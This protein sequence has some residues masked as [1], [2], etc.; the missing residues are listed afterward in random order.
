MMRQ[1][2]LTRIWNFKNF[3]RKDP[4]LPFNGEGRL[5][6]EGDEEMVREM[7]GRKGQKGF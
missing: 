2:L 7:G 1:N 3:L 6:R 4:G 5:G